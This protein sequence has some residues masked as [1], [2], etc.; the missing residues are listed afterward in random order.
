MVV[1][2]VQAEAGI[3]TPQNN[4]LQALR[5]RC[6]D[7]GTLLILDEVQ[8]GYGRT[9]TLFAMEQHQLVP[10]ILCIAKGMGGGMPI[11]AFIASNEVMAHLKDNPILGHI[12]TF[13]GHPV[14]C[15]AALATLKTLQESQLI[16]SVKAKE[17]LFLKHLTHSAIKEVRSAGLMIA[18]E[19]ESF[20]F[21]QAVI[22]QCLQRGIIVDWF[23]FND[24]SMRIAPPLI[25]T[26]EE[27][28]TACSRINEAI[29][30]ALSAT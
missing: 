2:A 29:D 16:E 30:A 23:L 14:S 17:A 10:D 27:I 8:T 7:T 12:S 9:G 24:R 3:Y 22:D 21:L 18:V 25:I 28:S 4:F 13:G 15:A 1:E 5:Q 11:G 6:T 19:L 26:E 20:E